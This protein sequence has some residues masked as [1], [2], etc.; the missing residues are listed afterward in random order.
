MPLPWAWAGTVAAILLAA[1]GGGG[2]GPGL[3]RDYPT[4]VPVSD[5][6]RFAALDTSQAHACGTTFDGRTWCWGINEY[7]EL[8]STAA[9]DLCDIPGIT[10]VACTGTPLRVS[11]APVFA[12]LASSR[13]HGSSCGLT[14]AG[15][16][17]CWDFGLGGQL[18]DGRSA[19]SA[20]P[21]AV[22]GGLQFALLRMSSSSLASCGLTHS[23][24]GWCW[25]PVADLWGHGAGVGSNVPV[26][27][28]WGRSF[29]TLDL[30]ELHG[31][32][33]TAAGQAWC[34][35]SNWYGQLGVGSAGGSGGL[36]SSGTPRAVVGA[37]VWRSIATGS[38][39]SC[40][41]DDTGAAWCW[42]VAHA[43]GSP[44]S[45]PDYVG[46][47]QRV[48]GGQVFTALKSGQLH[49]CGLTAQGEV[50]CWG[51]N[52]GGELGDGSHAPTQTPVRVQTSA[53]FAALA[54]RATCALTAD[55]QA[56]C[57]GDNSYGQVGR[58]SHW[59]R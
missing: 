2:S 10:L 59:A 25:G 37:Q 54:H 23:G 51:L 5:S 8:G 26:R 21:V 33:L 6:L 44:T 29:V 52:Y 57:W 40:A 9:I 41:L 53:R 46:T 38:D 4:P 55:G 15:A 20:Q 18:G 19:D 47:P 7:G 50:W 58:R 43:I 35:G 36:F 31:C 48:A 28:D 16:A 24:E 11:G 56:W 32:G 49:T 12:V 45:V 17:W 39:H 34:W 30:G 27:V 14:A 22:A 3:P 1:C 13:G 42:G